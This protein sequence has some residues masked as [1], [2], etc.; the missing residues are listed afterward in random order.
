MNSFEDP[1]VVASYITIMKNAD[2]LRAQDR[3]L[4]QNQMNGAPPLT[5][6]EAEDNAVEVNVNFQTS[7][8]A[9]H[10][11]RRQLENAMTKTTDYFSVTL[12]GAPP[13]YAGKWGMAITKR[14]NRIMKK[15]LS[16]MET[17]RSTMAGVVMHGI[18]ARIWRNPDCW[19]ADF[20]P[21]EDI[22]MP[23]NTEIS[24]RKTTYFATRHSYSYFELV[25]ILLNEKRDPGWNTEAI[26][27]FLDTVK[28]SNGPQT[29]Q[30]TWVDAPE[31]M[32]ENFKQNRTAWETDSV[33]AIW[34][35]NFYFEHPKKRK[36]FMNMVVDVP[37]TT[38]STLANGTGPGKFLYVGRRSVG[39]CMG[40]IIHFQFA[41]GNNKA[42]FMY[43]SVRGLGYMLYDIVELENRLRCQFFQH[44]FESLNMLFR[45]GNPN[46]RGR[47]NKI[48]LL[49]KGVVPSDVSILGPNER[50]QVDNALV[51][52]TF[53]NIKQII[54][55]TTA[56]Y[57]SDSDNGTQKE[58]TATA[59]MAKIQDINALLSQMLSM[60]YNYEKAFQEETCRRFTK[61]YS[62]DP[63]V[64]KFRRQC[65]ADGVP[66]EWIDSERWT[67]KPEMV[68]GGGHKVLEMAQSDRLMSM[69]GMLPAES[70]EKVKRMHIAALTDNSDLAENLV[71]IVR[72]TS[73]TST[74]DAELAFGAMMGGSP[75]Q[76]LKG[77]NRLEQI[78]TMLGLMNMKVQSINQSGGVGTRE[79]VLGLSLCVNYVETIAKTMAMDPGS[80][81][82]LKQVE[83]QLAQVENQL[84]AFAQRQMEEEQKQQQQL[85]PAKM[86][87]LELEK[88]KQM[89]DLQMDGER[90]KL[91]NMRL[92]AQIEQ[93]NRQVEARIRA[94][95]EKT[96][97]DIERK[98]ME[99]AADVTRE[100]AKV[101]ANIVMQEKKTDADIKATEKKAE[102]ASRLQK[103]T[104]K[105]K[106][107]SS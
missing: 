47:T 22:L 66:E 63:E 77:M 101:E 8:R 94:E 20:V 55:E 96:A 32:A 80:K 70:Q 37:G 46:D 76:P 31:K 83:T 52:T 91:E 6:Q 97:A 86:A 104:A 30:F 62:I 82:L 78:Q 67:V 14:I 1:N 26:K 16:Y 53:A 58:E 56:G 4:I 42:P 79:D 34:V 2:T 99:A 64:R 74:H 45:I 11:A 61:R 39:S 71:P 18:G 92:M 3:V 100:N 81:E 50:Y 57:T 54:S 29:N 103:K 106:V 90:L 21:I 84:K 69:I 9:G 59:V 88:Q 25:E 35:W 38:A 65:I 98:N 27:E 41:D 102:A 107:A 68:L 95:Q 85:D 5:Q 93:S 49:N 24:F 60:A 7:A 75:V 19:E 40:E 15:K 33:P 13:D 10:R 105:K 51:Q 17:I 48:M 89:F 72:P 36:W 44:V 43:H 87:E 28:P 23:T 73:T 12:D